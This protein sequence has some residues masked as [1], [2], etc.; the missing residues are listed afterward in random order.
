VL[1]IL[2][3]THFK[4]ARALQAVF[5]ST[6]DLAAR[7]TRFMQRRSKLS[8]SAFVQALTF[9]W[10]Q[11]P[12]AS[13]EE[14]AQAAG[15]LGVPISPQGLDQRFGPRAAA[16]L[17][18]V[19]QEA[20]LQVISADPVAVPLLQRFA[21]VCLL[22]STTITLPAAFAKTWPGS[23]SH[24]KPAGIKVQVRLDLLNGTLT[25]PLLC[26]GRQHDQAGALQTVPVPRGALRLADLGYFSLE[27]LRTLDQEGVWWLTR[28]GLETRLVDAAGQ[29]WSL[30]NFLSQHQADSVDVSMAMG[31][32]QRLPCRFLAIR[33]PAE[34]AAKRRRHLRQRGKE[35]GW[36]VHPDRFALAAWNFYATNVPRGQL[37]LQEA[38]VLVRCRWQI[39][40]LFKLWK[41]EGRVDESSS[42]KPW[43]ILCEVYAKLLGM[44]VQHWL[45]LVGCWS[46]PD[47]SLVKASRTVRAHA[48]A[49][50]L[51]L[52][53]GHLVYKILEQIRRCLAK[54][55][56]I[57][58]RRRDPP[59][60]QRLRDLPKAG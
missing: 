9:G 20:V 41:S 6:A 3:P 48:M 15:N 18:R 36:K 39:E 21:G 14:L 50:A 58:H 43:R 35:R 11:N 24:H 46:H 57:N 13:L 12:Q 33:V 47:R 4:V 28:I 42:D 37:T 31:L 55:C 59:T 51:V 60:F 16:M 8:G 23:G 53:H 10:L 29:V 2:S 40:L 25:G 26:P 32:E 7:Q 5:T 22:D 27:R 38:V 54:G 17:E 52:E 1:T 49:L 45:L 30:A 56:R 19:L 34:V 44:V